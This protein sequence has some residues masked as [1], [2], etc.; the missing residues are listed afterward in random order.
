MF[1]SRGTGKFKKTD[2]S[3]FGK[4]IIIENT[5]LIFH[6]ENVELGDGIYVGHYTILEGY[7]KNKL[8]VGK[9][10]WIGPQCYIHGAG[11]I[12]IEKNV[13][14][15]AGVKILSSSHSLDCAGKPILH[16][17]IIFAPVHIGDGADI[18]VGAVIL[19]GVRIGKCAQIGAGAVVTADI[20]DNAVAA[21]VP[22]RVIRKRK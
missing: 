19:P 16:N 17:E 3:I 6:P 5:A 9:G 4:E 10:T 8:V 14:I 20:A 11:G 1:K 12:K 15:G 21:G 18:G 2:F 7:Y 22:A 13:G